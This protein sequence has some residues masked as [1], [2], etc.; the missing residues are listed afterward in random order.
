[1]IYFWICKVFGGIWYDL[2][3]GGGLCLLRNELPNGAFRNSFRRKYELWN[4][5]FRN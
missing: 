1:M 4:R 2:R 5:V 3:F